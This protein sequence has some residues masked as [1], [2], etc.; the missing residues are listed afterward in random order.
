MRLGDGAPVA[1]DDA[2]A[3]EV[4]S[5]FAPWPQTIE[6]TAVDPSGNA[7]TTR[8]SVMGGV[9]IRQLPWPAILAVSVIAVVALSSLRGGRRIRPAVSMAAATDDDR[10]PVIEELSSGPTERRD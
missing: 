8:V 3:F 4:R 5:Q 7:T 1:V 6:V 2:G 10:L 9:D